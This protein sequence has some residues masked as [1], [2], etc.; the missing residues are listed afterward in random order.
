MNY[1]FNTLNVNSYLLPLCLS[2]TRISGYFFFSSLLPMCILKQSFLMWSFLLFELD[3]QRLLTNLMWA[4]GQNPHSVKINFEKLEEGN[5][6]LWPSYSDKPSVLYPLNLKY[7]KYKIVSLSYYQTVLEEPM[8]V[9][10]QSEHLVLLHLHMW[11][12]RKL[13]VMRKS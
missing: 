6:T 9:Q 8:M 4:T 1:A 7:F 13:C 12:T 10:T 2:F 3:I 11:N 5:L